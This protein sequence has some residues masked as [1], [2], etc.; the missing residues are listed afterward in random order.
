MK[1]ETSA[2]HASP[3]PVDGSYAW[4]RLT[5]SVLI[6]AISGIG[7][8]AFV[9]VLPTVESDFGIDRASASLPYTMTMAGFAIGNVIFGRFVDRVGIVMPTIIAAVALGGGFIASALTSEIWQ[10]TVIHGP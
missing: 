1:S 3:S 7:L 4:F 8:W 2:A 5:I 10:F 9:V 6:S